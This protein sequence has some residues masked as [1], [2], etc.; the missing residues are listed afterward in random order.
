MRR[1]Q[2]KFEIILAILLIIN[3]VIS[4]V[5]VVYIAGMSSGLSEISNQLQSL[6]GL[7]QEI[8][9]IINEAIS[10]INVTTPSQN[11][12]SG[13]LEYGG[14]IKVGMTL[15]FKGKFTH[16]SEMTLIGVK[17]GVKW[18]NDHGGII[19]GN[20]RYNISVIV[21]DDESD[22]KLVPELY[23]RLIERD[24][25]NVLL[26][27]YSSGLTMAAVTA[28]E[29]HGMVLVDINGVSDSIF[30]R[31]YKYIVLVHNKASDYMR[32]IVDMLASMNDPDIKVALIFENSPFAVYAYQGAK[33]E[34]EKYGMEVVYEKLYEKGATEFGSIV[35]EAMAA[36]ANVL[37][38]GGHYVDGE[39]LVKQAWEL[40]WKLKAVGIMIA[41]AIPSFYE[42][43]QQIAENVLTQEQWEIGVKYSPEVAQQLGLEWIGPTQEEFLE[44]CKMIDPETTPTYHS[45][46]GFTGLLLIKKAIEEAQS[47]NPDLIRS[48]FNRMHVMTFFGEFKIDPETGIQIG[49]KMIVVQWQNGEK[50]IV[51][52]P[53]AATG[54]FIYP[55]PNWW[56]R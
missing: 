33:E 15:S 37:I 42:E 38:G 28:T 51:W 49:H 2:S 11:P 4:G 27:P 34:L 25:V 20:K 7:P 5:A 41:P 19:I 55:A 9:N 12:P 21:Y 17:A 45:A 16:E 39:A 40:G 53:E 22:P 18:I 36:G 10:K 50:V 6:S 8:S 3:I 32:Q 26:G 47:L 13:E 31:G 46:L 30:E 54:E 56:E 24:K 1:G 43:L 14:E 23:S 48:A 29:E 52:P 35:S 44:Y